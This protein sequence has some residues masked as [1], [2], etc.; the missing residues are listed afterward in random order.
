MIRLLI[1]L[2]FLK[3]S[4]SLKNNISFNL[5]LLMILFQFYF[6]I[7][8]VLSPLLNVSSLELC[9]KDVVHLFHCLTHPQHLILSW[10]SLID[11]L[12]FNALQI[13]MGYLIPLFKLLLILLL[14]LSL[15]LKLLRKHVR[16]N[17]CKKSFELFMTVTWNIIVLSYQHQ[18]SWLQMCLYNKVI[19]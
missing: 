19:A 10:L 14:H 8:M 18:T 9:I 15:T 5:L 7:L 16:S 17:Q 13:G 3:M 4:C 1:N 2:V 6:L 11:Y 12:R